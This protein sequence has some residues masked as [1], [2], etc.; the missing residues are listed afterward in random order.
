MA[1]AETSSTPKPSLPKPVAPE[2]SWRKFIPL[3]PAAETIRPLDDG[4]RR[5]LQGDLLRNGQREPVV[6]RVKEEGSEPSLLDGRHRLD[7][8]EANGKEV[9]DDHGKL[10]APHRIVVLPNEADAVSYVLSLNAFRRHLSLNERRELTK[11]ILAATP[12]KS[13]RQIGEIIGLNKTTVGKL[14]KEGE[15]R[16][17]V[18]K[19]D[20]AT[21]H[22]GRKQTRRRKAKT[23]TISAAAPAPPKGPP[24]SITRV[25]TQAASNTDVAPSMM[26]AQ[27]KE[28]S[29]PV[30]SDKIISAQDARMP[31]PIELC[32]GWLKAS[33]K[34][35]TVFA[36]LYGADVRHHRTHPDAALTPPRDSLRWRDE[37]YQQ[38]RRR[39]APHM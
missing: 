5:A 3:D 8:Q 16:G 9:I 27:S 29:T 30:K 22:E 11:K 36:D 26:A 1:Q 17:T 28:Q 32:H 33:N 7:L 37:R 20:T 18:S 24:I 12:E 35:R 38:E 21:D 6:L 2:R 15:R 19:M 14:R 31:G 23:K 39:S 34:E 4:E 25:V 13:D 10:T